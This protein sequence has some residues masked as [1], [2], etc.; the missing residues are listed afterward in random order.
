MGCIPGGNK[1]ALTDAEKSGFNT[2]AATGC[3]WCHYGPYL[4][5]ASYQKLGVVKPW[6]NQTDQGLYQVTKGGMDKMVFKVPS[7]RNIKKTGPRSSMTARF[8]R[9]TRRSATWRFINV[10]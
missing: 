7:L 6:P 4:G 8:R 10:D 2:F 3:Q 1:S 5:G 9:W